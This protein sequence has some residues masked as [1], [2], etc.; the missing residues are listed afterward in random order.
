MAQLAPVEILA[1]ADGL[2]YGIV[3]PKFFILQRRNRDVENGKNQIVAAKFALALEE[4]VEFEGAMLAAQCPGV[5]IGMKNTDWAM[6][7]AISFSQSVPSEIAALSC[8]T[9]IVLRTA[10]LRA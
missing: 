3:A 5:T 7:W 2:Q 4:G 6:P 9:R 8:Q 1:G 10:E